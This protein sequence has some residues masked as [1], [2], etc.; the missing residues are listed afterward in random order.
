MSFH[1]RFS[2]LARRNFA[3]AQGVFA[4]DSA[5]RTLKSWWPAAGTREGSPTFSIEI[6][7]VEGTRKESPRDLAGLAD[8]RSTGKSIMINPAKLTY[9]PQKEHLLKLG[10]TESTARKFRVT[11]IQEAGGLIQLEITSVL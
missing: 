4:T 1:T 8:R 2:D 9:S 11:D 7:A 5:G 10:Y 6:P 3:V